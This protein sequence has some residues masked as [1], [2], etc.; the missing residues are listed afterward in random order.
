MCNC[1]FTTHTAPIVILSIDVRRINLN[2]AGAVFCR[3][4]AVWHLCEHASRVLQ[5]HEALGGVESETLHESGRAEQ[6]IA[7]G[8]WTSKGG[9]LL[10]QVQERNQAQ[11]V[12]DAPA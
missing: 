1:N 8:G 12:A 5:R 4:V 2:P 11:M 9:V 7:A 3:Q 10:K 6:G